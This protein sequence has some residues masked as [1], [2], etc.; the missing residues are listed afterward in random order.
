[1]SS[2]YYVAVFPSGDLDRIEGPFTGEEAAYGRHGDVFVEAENSPHDIVYCFVVPTEKKR[3]LRWYN[4]E[5]SDLD[6]KWE[7]LLDTLLE[8]ETP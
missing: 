7:T 8:K 2:E 4:D 6:M 3:Y 5:H 1:M